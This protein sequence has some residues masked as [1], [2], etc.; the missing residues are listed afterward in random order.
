MLAHDSRR[1]LRDLEDGNGFHATTDVR[2]KLEDLTAIEVAEGES[3]IE[4]RRRGSE[5]IGERDIHDERPLAGE[6]VLPA[7]T[8]A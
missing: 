5:G 8:L 1:L 7:A 4:F 3:A 2:E 6:A